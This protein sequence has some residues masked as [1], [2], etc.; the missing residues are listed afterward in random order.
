MMNDLMESCLDLMSFSF[1]DVNVVL[2]SGVVFEN[3]AFIMS[4]GTSAMRYELFAG[5]KYLM[6]RIGLI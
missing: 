1:M 3:Y 6:P 5:I 4:R 2:Q